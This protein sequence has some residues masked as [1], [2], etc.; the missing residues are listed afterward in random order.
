MQPMAATEPAHQVRWGLGDAALGWVASLVAATAA[1]VVAFMVVAEEG[2]DPTLWFEE[3]SIVGIALLQLPLSAVLLVWPLG[4]TALKGNGAV[5]DLGLA[6]ERRD[7]GIGLAAGLGAQVLLP[8][9]YLPLL[10]ILG[11][12]ADVSGV[13][14]ELTGRA[15][16]V[17]QVAILY[18]VVGVLAPVSEEVFYRGLVLRG[19]ERRIDPRAALWVQALLFGAAHFQPLQF[20]G[21]A[22]FGL[23]AGVLVQRTGRLGASIVAHLAFNA[24]AVTLLLVSGG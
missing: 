15:S 6:I 22:A 18:L 20:L 12:D 10:A 14:R 24:T 11:D 7:V 23:L 19:L 1:S 2:A 3:L 9:L 5:R 17:G 16:G 4:V 8:L 13:A 21:Q